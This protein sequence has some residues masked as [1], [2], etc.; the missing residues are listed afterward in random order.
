M[1]CSPGLSPATTR[2]PLLSPPASPS[3]T[4]T[5]FCGM[6]Y[7]ITTIPATV[8]DFPREK[9]AP[10][11]HYQE[12]RCSYDTILLV[13]S[14]VF[15]A[16]AGRYISYVAPSC[17]PSGVLYFALSDVFKDPALVPTV[18]AMNSLMAVSSGSDLQVTIGNYSTNALISSASSPTYEFIYFCSLLSSIELK[19]I[20]PLFQALSCSR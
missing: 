1:I 18:Y 15:S 20:A 5:S 12:I 13:S 9:F 14:I 8:R 11:K 4:Y 16:P 3:G 17:S 7:T 10:S 2:L 6:I 19:L